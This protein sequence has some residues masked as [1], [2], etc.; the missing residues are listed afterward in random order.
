M[1]IDYKLMTAIMAHESKFDPQARSSTGA[2]GLGQ[3]TGTAITE[4]KRLGKLGKEPYSNHLA[5]FE[6][7]GQR[8]ANRTHIADNVTTSAAYIRLMQE[9]SGTSNRRLLQNYNGEPGR[10]ESYPNQVQNDYQQLWGQP[11]PARRIAAQ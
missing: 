6:R 10:R 7:I 1:G 3:L 9:R 11:M 2:R 8:S 5:T 4:L